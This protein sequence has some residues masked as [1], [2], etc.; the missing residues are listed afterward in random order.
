MAPL[1]TEA[2]GLVTVAQHTIRFTDKKQK[3]VILRMYVLIIKLCQQYV[4][5]K[6]EHFIITRDLYQPN[7]GPIDLET[8]CHLLRESG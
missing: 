2:D 6:H 7:F 5:L 3:Q 4:F 8:L 1:H